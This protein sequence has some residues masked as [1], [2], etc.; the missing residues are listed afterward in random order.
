M[1][2]HGTPTFA[3]EYWNDKLTRDAA[4][5]LTITGSEGPVI[6]NIDAV[7]AAG[8]NVSGRVTDSNGSPIQN[9]CVDAAVETSN[10]FDGVGGASTAADGSYTMNGLPPTAVKVAFRDC[11]TVG[12]YVQEWWN[13]APNVDAASPIALAPGDTLTGIDAQLAPAGAITGTVTDGGGNP[14]EGICAQASTSTFTGN[15]ATTDSNGQ[16]S[17][18]LGLAGDYKV[19]FV[20]CSGSPSFA[21]EWWNDQ[22]TAA[23]AQ[24]VHVDAGSGRARHR[25]GPRR[26]CTRVD[27]REGRQRA[28]HRD[29]IG[30]RRGL[31]PVPVRALRPGPTRRLVHDPERPV[32]APTPSRS[33]AVPRAEN[34]QP[35]VPDPDISGVEYNALWW[36]G[37]RLDI[38]G[39]GQGEGGP[40]PVMQGANLVTV[41]PGTNLVGYDA[42][43]RV[44][45]DHD[46]VDHPGTEL[47]HG[48]VH[49]TERG[50]NGCRSTRTSPSPTPSRARRRTAA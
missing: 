14:L 18:V 9:I 7:L 28:R 35:I 44:H 26:R 16:Y 27:L 30:V 39:G 49:D 2:F 32:R 46:H 20:D 3:G 4:D 22:A 36:N 33:S 23:A 29:D 5:V 8:A 47:A 10:G 17:I 38:T 24:T 45:V 12:P 41:T 40:D 43:L 31:P 13:D 11:N 15:L 48:R 1:Q 21:G 19:Q 34:P 25:R 50:C 6:G 37:V 42:L